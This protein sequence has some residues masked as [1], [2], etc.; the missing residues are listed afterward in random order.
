[1]LLLNSPATGSGSRA[2]FTAGS[3]FL[4]ASISSFVSWTAS[5]ARTIGSAATLNI[6]LYIMYIYLYI[7]IRKLIISINLI[8][9]AILSSSGVSVSSRWSSIFGSWTGSF[10]LHLFLK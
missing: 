3:T 8:P 4:A 1:M 10:I 2:A 9:W 7:K 5:W 6:F